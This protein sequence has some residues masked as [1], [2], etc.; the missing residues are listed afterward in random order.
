MV[1]GD[2]LYG[3]DD[4][5]SRRGRSRTRTSDPESNFMSFPPMVN[6][7]GAWIVAPPRSCKRIGKYFLILV[8]AIISISFWLPLS[9]F[10]LGRIEEYTYPFCSLPES[11]IVELRD[12]LAEYKHR[13]EECNISSLDLHMPL[14]TVCPDRSSMLAAMSSGGRVGRDAPYLPRGCD[15]QWFDTWEVCDILGRYSQVVL[16][17][18]SMLR[19]VIGALNILI[20]EDLGYGGVTDWNFS[21]EER[22]DRSR[23]VPSIRFVLPRF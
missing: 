6:S 7:T 2:S 22:Y 16:V 18:D 20:R 3:Y 21:E 4:K 10:H 5:D 9:E 13:G 11:R 19:H 17:G 23:Q 12:T 1:Y 15:M 8:A 14:G